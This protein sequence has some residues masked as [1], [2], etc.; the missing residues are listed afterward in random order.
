MATNILTVHSEVLCYIQNNLSSTAK[1]ILLASLAGFFTTDEINNAKC[2]LFS[3]AEKLK[4]SGTAIDI[5]RMVTRRSGDGK[6]KADIDDVFDLWERLD[7]AKAVL[8]VF[9][10]INLSRIPPLSFSSADVCSLS[11]MV[12]DM[13]LQLDVMQGKFSEL[14]CQ[15]KKNVNRQVSVA[16]TSLSTRTDHSSSSQVDHSSSAPDGLRKSDP[17]VTMMNDPFWWTVT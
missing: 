3:E 15:I 5:P 1:S 8:P 12:H 13:K 2:L 17:L 14:A 10:A 16:A 6:K 7:T 4:A 11:A 9:H